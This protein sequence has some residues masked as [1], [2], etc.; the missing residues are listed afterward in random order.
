MSGLRSALDELRATDLGALSDSEIEDSLTEILEASESLEAEKLR[1]LA[2]VDRRR[3]F[4]EGGSLSAASWLASR[5]A[6]GR[7]QRGRSCE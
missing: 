4:A 6:M 7:P 2:E 3:S 1:W 5:P